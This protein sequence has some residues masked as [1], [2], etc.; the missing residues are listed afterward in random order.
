ML[1]RMKIGKK[2]IRKHEIFQRCKNKTTKTYPIDNPLH[3]CQKKRSRTTLSAKKTR[4]NY[5]ETGSQN[6][7][8][9]RNSDKMN[10]KSW[11]TPKENEIK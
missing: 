2:N 1:K 7:K 10:A 8:Q 4:V 5:D 9:K 11:P 6:E 3:L